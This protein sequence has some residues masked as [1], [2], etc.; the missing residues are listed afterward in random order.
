MTF[1]RFRL[2]IGDEERERE[3]ERDGIWIGVENLSV[4]VFLLVQYSV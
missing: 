2:S 1:C 3:R 4:H